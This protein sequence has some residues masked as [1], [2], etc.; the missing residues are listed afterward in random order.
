MIFET[1]ARRARQSGDTRNP[2]PRLPREADHSSRPARATK[3]AGAA[4]APAPTAS[5]PRPRAHK[6][7][8]APR[9]CSAIVI[10]PPLNASSFRPREPESW[11]P[12]S[13]SP[14]AMDVSSIRAGRFSCPDAV[15]RFTN[16]GG[17]EAAR[18]S[19]TE[20]ERHE[21]FHLASIVGLRRP[22]DQLRHRGH[23][24]LGHDVVAVVFHR[25][26]R[27]I[28][29]R[30]RWPCWSCPRSPDAARRVR[31]R[32]GRRAVVPGCAS[33]A[34]RRKSSALAASASPIRSSST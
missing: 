24:G 23:A 13:C 10:I 34:R 8:K 19:G 25:L 15:P 16:L 4:Q 7:A 20:P 29:I 21:G 31:V 2:E 12:G 17:G 11:R 18:L 1:L 28:E 14:S 30:A 6:D 9:R 32:S 27:N 22:G 33:L 3:L 26:H 5:E